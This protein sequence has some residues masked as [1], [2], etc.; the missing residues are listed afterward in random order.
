MD[1]LQARSCPGDAADVVA[2]VVVDV[3]SGVYLASVPGL[4][5]ASASAAFVL[6]LAPAAEV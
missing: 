5:D 2:A 1:R 6:A 4:E 3:A